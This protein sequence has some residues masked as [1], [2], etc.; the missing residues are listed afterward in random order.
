MDVPRVPVP[1]RPRTKWVALWLPLSTVVGHPRIARR[2]PV[3][4]NSTWYVINLRR[5]E[6]VDEQVRAWLTEAYLASP[7]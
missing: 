6:D 1:L 2:V 3:S 7:V 4:G 5:P